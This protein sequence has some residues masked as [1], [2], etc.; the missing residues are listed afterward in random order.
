M[1]ASAT[2]H[3]LP[4]NHVP[5]YYAGGANIERF[6]R[7]PAAARYAVAVRRADGTTTATAVRA[8]RVTVCRCRGRLRVTVVP[9]GA[10]GRPGP[11]A[12]RALRCR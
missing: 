7:Q 6:R 5:V 4:A 11:R 12:S 8:P 1:K 2:P 9:L 3:H 10:D